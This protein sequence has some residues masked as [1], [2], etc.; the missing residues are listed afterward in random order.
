MRATINTKDSSP[1]PKG[2]ILLMDSL[3]GLALL[4]VLLANLSSFA[5]PSLSGINGLLNDIGD[6]LMNTKFLTLFSILFGAGFYMQ[7][8]KYQQKP[9][10]F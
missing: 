9:A 4:G 1:L 5:N 6:V 10:F 8:E 7:W 2:R 3:R